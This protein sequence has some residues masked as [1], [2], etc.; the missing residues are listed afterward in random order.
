MSS[1]AKE[2]FLINLED[3]MR[4]SYL[5]YA[6]SVIV[7]RALPD[8]CDGL[9]PVHRRVLYAMQVLNNEWNKPYKKSARVVGDVIGKYH[10]HGETAVYDTIVRMAQ[11]FSLRYTLV[12]GQGNF[13]SIDGDSPAAMR[14]TEVRMEKIT[15]EL[16]ADLDKE[17]VDFIPNYDNS[18]QEPTLLPT[19]IP[20]L[21][22]NGSSGIA[23]GMATN[24]PPHNLGEV[25]DAT[26]AMMTNPDIE[27]DELMQFL[28]GPDFPTAGI[29]NGRH[30]IRDAYE[31]GRG[32]LVVRSR[33]HTEKEEK[34]GRE[35]IVITELPYTVNKAQLVEKIAEL[36]KTKKMEGISELRDESD[37]DG[38][39][40]VITL[41]RDEQSDIVL[42][43]LYRHTRM[44]MFFGVNM[45][46]IESN[47]P[48]LVNLRDILSAFIRHRRTIVT[49]R[50]IYSLRKAKEKAHIL[51]GQAIALANIDEVIAL[52][53]ASPTPAIAK[54]ALVDKVWEAGEVIAKLLERSDQDVTMTRP[55]NIGSEY[56]LTDG[57][58]RL[59]E[60]QAQAI[61]D[62]RLHRLTS[63]EQDKIIKDYE[64]LIQQITELMHILT[65][66]DRLME[67]ISD[68]L[69]EVKEKYNDKRRTEISGEVVDMTDEDFI[70]DEDVIV[71][72]SHGGYI[73]AQEIDVYKAQKRGGRGKKAAAVK[74]EDF[75]D[76]IFVAKTHDT[77]L[78]FSSLGK[79]HWLKVYKVPRA[80]RTARGKPIVNLLNLDANERIT[81]VLPVREYKEDLSVVLATR[82]GRIK[83]TP[84]SGFSNPRK[85]GIRAINLNENDELIGADITDGNYEIMLFNNIGRVV[86]FKE[87]DLRLLGRTA[88]GVMGIRLREKQKAISLICVSPDEIEKTILIASE[89]GYGKRTQVGDFALRKRGG[90]GVIGIRSDERNGRVIGAQLVGEDDEIMLITSG[91]T[92]VRTLSSGISI[93]G[94]VTKGVRLIKLSGKEKLSEIIKIQNQGEDEDEGEDKDEILEDTDHNSQ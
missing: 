14:Y 21:L 60:I 17:T 88:S 35:L 26:L 64:A 65:D 10:P 12:D 49:R 76:S 2:L 7:G 30:G 52:I 36:V 63:L 9:K 34:T 59:S 4:K 13:G 94:R 57:M 38:M 20:N 29:I 40:V 16:L 78:C 5:D 23:V 90:L 42:N 33:S 53:K 67:V 6:M 28:P 41:K 79:V 45:V 8:I 82:A 15:Q 71:T 43:N 85:S 46:A 87:S 66:P 91:G 24:I 1:F 68:E 89:N 25:I 86:H 93:V 18:E 84:L 69:I 58:Y 22:I 50:T 31:T 77:L 81:V 32:R 75:V 54:K 70:V 80:G 72:V 48:K 73:K 44:Q 92:L 3:E 74:E 11:D 47:Q 61:L 39:R 19:K 37:K 56:G 51:E 27:V 55:D 83:R 62:L